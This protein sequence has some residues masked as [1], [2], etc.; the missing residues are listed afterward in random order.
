MHECCEFVT[1]NRARYLEEVADAALE[2]RDR[3]P[4]QE[5]LQDGVGPLLRSGSS[6]LDSAVRLCGLLAEVFPSRATDVWSW[7][8]PEGRIP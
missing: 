4:L 3:L 8:K 1:G 7:V 6:R 2:C 5:W